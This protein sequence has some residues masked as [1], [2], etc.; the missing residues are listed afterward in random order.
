MTMPADKEARKRGLHVR[1]LPI[2]NA[3]IHRRI[4]ER[5]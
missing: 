1:M 4:I 2:T 3:T 5:S